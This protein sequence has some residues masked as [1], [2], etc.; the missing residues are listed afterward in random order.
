MEFAYTIT[1]D[2]DDVERIYSLTIIRGDETVDFTEIPDQVPTVNLQ[3]GQTVTIRQVVEVNV[4][5][6]GSGV[7]DTQADVVTGPPCDVEVCTS[8]CFIISL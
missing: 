2:G 7:F 1:N 5:T 6:G 4:C 8:I 3:P